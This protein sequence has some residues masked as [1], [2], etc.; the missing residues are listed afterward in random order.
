MVEK[1][2]QSSCSPRPAGRSV[3]CIHMKQT[4]FH[5]TT[6]PLWIMDLKMW[7]RKFTPTRLAPPSPLLKDIAPSPLWI[8]EMLVIILRTR[9]LSPANLADPRIFFQIWGAAQ[10]E[11]CTWWKCRCKAVSREDRWAV[12]IYH[13]LECCERKGSGRAVSP[14]ERRRN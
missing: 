9:S 4:K 2:R 12:L 14:K 5:T 6:N 1:Q 3:M 8:V 10:H 11:T 7:F 13:H